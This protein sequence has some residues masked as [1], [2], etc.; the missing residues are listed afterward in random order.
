MIRDLLDPDALYPARLAGTHAWA[1]WGLT[2]HADPHRLE[3]AVPARYPNG[4]AHNLLGRIATR[5]AEPVWPAT[6]PPPIDV[7]GRTLRYLHDGQPATLE[8]LDL[9]WYRPAST[10]RPDGEAVTID[11]WPVMDEAAAT[12]QRFEA[13]A[14]HGATGRDVTD[15]TRWIQLKTAQT[16]G[17]RTAPTQ[18]GQLLTQLHRDAP[19]AVGIDTVIDHARTTYLRTVDPDSIR[20]AFQTL[21]R[22][23]A[24]L[25]ATTRGRVE[26]SRH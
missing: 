1:V 17:Y 16:E 20:D 12:R 25:T 24:R 18:I 5:L 23:L 8:L 15:V 14:T 4:Y 11:G 3:L 13:I 19:V 26:L 9:P 22:E 10:P 2:E 7:G 6:D 21:T